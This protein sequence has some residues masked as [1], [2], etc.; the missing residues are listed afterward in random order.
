MRNKYIEYIK[1]LYALELKKWFLEEHNVDILEYIFK[2]IGPNSLCEIHED[3]SCEIDLLVERVERNEIV[4]N[5]KT[6]RGKYRNIR[7][8]SNKVRDTKEL[9]DDIKYNRKSLEADK[10]CPG[11]YAR[12][13]TGLLE[14]DKTFTTSLFNILE[15]CITSKIN[16]NKKGYRKETLFLNLEDIKKTF[17]L[18][19]D[20]CDLIMLH[21]LTETD[22][23]VED[24]FSRGDLDIRS[25]KNI[26]YISR[27]LDIPISSLKVCLKRRSLLRSASILTQNRSNDIEIDPRICDFLNGVG[28]SNLFN[29]FFSEPKDFNKIDSEE[30]LDSKKVDLL[31][32]IIS[33]KGA[34]NILFHGEPGVGKTALVN[35]I[36][37]ELDIAVFEVNQS[38]DNDGEDIGNRKTALVAAQNLLNDKECVV[39]VDEADELISKTNP[40]MFFGNSGSKDDKKS[41]INQYLE[42]SKLKIIWITNHCTGMDDSTKRRFSYIEKFSELTQNQRESVL[43]KQLK[44]NKSKL[45]NKE[46]V[47]EISRTYNVSAGTI[48]MALRESSNL[49]GEDEEKKTVALEI[50]KSHQ[51]FIKGEVKKLDFRKETYDVTVL[52]ADTDITKLVETLGL[53]K[54]FLD[55]KAFDEIP[56]NMN[57]LF[58]GPPGT[59]KTEFAKYIADS[60]KTD[61]LLKRASDLKS[62]WVGESEQNIAAAFSEAERSGAILFLDE[63]DSLITSREGASASWEISETNELLTQMENFR[64]I[65]IC[66]TNFV[67]KL[68]SA[69]IRRFNNKV[70]FDYLED[71]GKV[72]LFKKFFKRKLK[73]KEKKELLAISNL[74]PGDFKVVHQKNFFFED[75]DTSKYLDDLRIESNYKSI[76]IKK[77]GLV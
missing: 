6:R 42:N 31:K 24:I 10:V 62:K 59:G 72:T 23:H 5:R 8:R 17:D 20:E 51:S 34:S 65:L 12:N 38:D 52:N 75:I 50:I 61:L 54:E 58:Q 53:Y 16:A 9:L 19:K 64:G 67:E 30:I 22:S 15:D 76:T 43:H 68:D 47:K 3:I 73:A 56:A 69:A 77:I 49:V 7:N 70:R 40:F 28:E 63:A 55:K 21:Y 71:S 27:L 35:A 39:L 41:W 46:E 13:I 74:T 37:K 11:S 66:N 14:I 57:L 25:S 44:L 18:N 26:K 29:T 1:G 36:A 32:K 60:L 33:S 45:F 48:S 4:N 2:I